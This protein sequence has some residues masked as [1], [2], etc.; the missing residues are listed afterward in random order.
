MLRPEFNPF[1]Q[2]VQAETFTQESNP[3]KPDG[4]P[5]TI[6]VPMKFPVGTANNEARMPLSKMP[7]H[8]PK[9]LF[10]KEVGHLVV[11]QERQPAAGRWEWNAHL[12]GHMASS[13]TEFYAAALEAS[14][15]QRTKELT[16]RTTD[17]QVYRTKLLRYMRQEH[18]R[19]RACRVHK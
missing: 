6:F 10:P 13:E 11:G 16:K 18:N 17:L 8:V 19:Q 1:D 14:L 9:I 2:Q 4:C 7:F 3:P 15:I 5:H 12:P